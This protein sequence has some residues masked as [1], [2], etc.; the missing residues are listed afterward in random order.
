MPSFGHAEDE[1]IPLRIAGAERKMTSQL[2]FIQQVLVA[3]RSEWTAFMA[4]HLR[5]QELSGSFGDIGTFLTLITIVA[6]KGIVDFGTALLF[7]G[8][9]NLCT[10]LWFDVP[11]AVQPMH[12]IA[13]IVAAQTL[14]NDEVIGAGLFM[15]VCLFFLGAT[16]LISEFK[17]S[18]PLSIIRGVLWLYISSHGS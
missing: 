9:F 15:G 13:S 10:V 6:S 14:T 17:N 1:N 18:V 5:L 7:N 4:A 16:N 8:I 2:P 3:T 11:I 12:A